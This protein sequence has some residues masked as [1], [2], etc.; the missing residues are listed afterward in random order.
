MPI[1]PPLWQMG[2][3]SAP[4]THIDN[5][6]KS[7]SHSRGM[8]VESGQK[9]CG[10]RFA[11]LLPQNML[12]ITYPVRDAL[13][14]PSSTAESRL[15]F[16]L[17]KGREKG[18][19]SPR[20]VLPL[21]MAD[22]YQQLYE[23]EYCLT[24]RQSG[25]YY[26][27]HIL[28]LSRRAHCTAG[29]GNCQGIFAP[30]RWIKNEPRGGFFIRSGVRSPGTPAPGH[31]SLSLLLVRRL[32][33]P[34]R[35]V[36]WSAIRLQRDGHDGIY[37]HLCRGRRINPHKCPPCPGRHQE[38]TLTGIPPLPLYHLKKSKSA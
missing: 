33:Q 34:C 1:P 2:A 22:Y 23:P 12:K 35:I 4:S 31:I 7:F 8:Q 5:I 17:P 15:Y 29:A 26:L 28:P 21:A 27:V 38:G 16:P 30:W 11:L 9:K 24:I 6:W 3:I 32:K 36:P 20:P 10:S 19:T 14:I 18:A 37:S 25:V 13:I